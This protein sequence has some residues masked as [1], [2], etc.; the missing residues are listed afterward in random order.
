[1]KRWAALLITIVLGMFV[2][3]RC[4]VDAY[5]EDEP[6]IS[7]VSVG[8]RPLTLSQ[9]V[10]I[11]A[12]HAPNSIVLRSEPEVSQLVAQPETGCT[13]YPELGFWVEAKARN[14]GDRQLT[15]W[16]SIITI[17]GRY[18]RSDLLSAELLICGE[19]SCL[20]YSF[21]AEEAFDFYPSDQI[22]LSL[23]EGNRW[24][25]WPDFQDEMVWFWLRLYSVDAEL[26]VSYHSELAVTVT[27]LV[28]EELNNFGDAISWPLEFVCDD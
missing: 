17:G 16:R 14:N 23:N 20:E 6:E 7:P 4:S 27:D 1:M 3:S 24:L 19:D 13:D 9:W 12:Q 5:G 8:A 26:P 25:T 28:S 10:T 18:L 11:D 22:L 21:V 15:D 2:A